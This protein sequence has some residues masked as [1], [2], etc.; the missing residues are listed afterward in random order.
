VTLKIWL[1]PQFDP[2]DGS[3]AGDM[4]QARLDEFAT[5]RPGVK[6]DVRV[7]DD[8]GLGGLLDSLSSASAAAP[9]ALPDLVALPHHTLETAAIKGLLHPYDEYIDTQNDADLYEFA[10]DLSYLQDSTFGVP[11]VGDALILVYRPSV[12]GSSPADW[13]TTLTITGPLSFPAADPLS[14]FTLNLYQS[15]GGPLLDAEGRPMLN[16]V[17]LTEVLTYYHKAEHSELMP[18]WLTQYETDQEAWT[19]YEENQAHLAV[20]WA[21]R[22]LKEPP[23]DTAAAPLPTKD[24]V[25]FT[26]ATGWVWALSSPDP[27]RRML[28]TELAEFL[29]ASDFLGQWTSAA[30]YLPPRPESLAYWSNTPLKALVSQIAPSAQLVP[31]LDV[32]TGLGPVLQSAT[33]DILK[34]QTD[35][36][37]AAAAAAEKLGGP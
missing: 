24:G 6:V 18:Y 16:P 36:I 37:S 20:T 35:P 25:P 31:S 4:L 33:M 34:E 12:V 15:L 10:S 2:S 1:P 8:E 21:S 7:K 27:E 11:F 9:L 23:M 13:V 26:L 5:R 30:G 19:A 14:L 28:S 32:L 17:Q 29:T 22:Y 3:I